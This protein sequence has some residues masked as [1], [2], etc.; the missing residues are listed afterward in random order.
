MENTTL[1]EYTMLAANIKE[2]GNQTSVQE[3][4]VDLAKAYFMYKVGKLTLSRER[5]SARVYVC[6]CVFSLNSSRD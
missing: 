2:Y 1:G 6:V 4:L 3:D 5:A